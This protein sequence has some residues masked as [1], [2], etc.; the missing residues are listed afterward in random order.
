MNSAEALTAPSVVSVLERMEVTHV[1][2]I[3]DNTS[4]DV[5]RLLSDHAAIDLVTVTREGEAFAI[6]AGVW[7]GGGRPLVLVQNTGLTESGDALRG[8]AVRMG[9]PV[10]VLVTCRGYAKMAG[11]GF[12]PGDALDVAT[13][14]R[15]D[16]DTVALVTEPTLDAWGIPWVRGD[17][18]ADV[19]AAIQRARMEERP[20][21]CLITSLS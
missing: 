3:P 21:A 15:P 8:T 5:F 14:T 4:A 19:T 18:A 20:V 10:P 7:L 12:T 6:A 2:G 17:S 11:A 16:V 1:V 9:A 13:L